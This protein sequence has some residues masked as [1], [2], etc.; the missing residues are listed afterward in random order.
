LS[1]DSQALVVLGQ[2]ALA[3]GGIGFDADI[4]RTKPT[5]LK[6]VQPMSRMANKQIGKLL[7][8]GTNTYM[9]DIQIVML[10]GP[11]EMRKMYDKTKDFGAKDAIL[12]FSLDMVRPDQRARVPQAM[13]CSACK[14]GNWDTWNKT[15]RREDLPPCRN[16]FRMFFVERTT[17]LPYYLNVEGASISA[18]K[19]AMGQVNRLGQ[20][21]LSNVKLE[22]QKLIAEGKAVKPAPSIF[23]IT[24]RVFVVPPAPT[25]KNQNYSLGFRDIKL[26]REEDRA[27]FGALYLQY[28]NLARAAGA[29]TPVDEPTDEDV[30]SAPAPG[31]TGAGAGSAPTQ[32]EG[33]VLPPTGGPTGSAKSDIVI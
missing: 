22:N 14:M 28:T 7:D 30:V 33:V 11:Q 2:E 9:D 3:K 32:P 25:D 20:L 31:P 1:S 15:H 27:E 4:F 17:R 19:E 13:A 10:G 24:F 21:A 6:L 5:F 8:T 23:D 12:C 16:Y 29:T 26:L 18:F